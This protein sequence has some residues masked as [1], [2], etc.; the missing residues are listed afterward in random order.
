MKR[1]DFEFNY[2]YQIM[3]REDGPYVLYEDHIKAMKEKD[4]KIEALKSLLSDARVRALKAQEGLLDVEQ[5]L[6]DTKTTVWRVMAAL[7]EADDLPMQKDPE[8]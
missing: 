7:E 2:G 8:K 1:Y 3:E 4:E 6:S 5:F